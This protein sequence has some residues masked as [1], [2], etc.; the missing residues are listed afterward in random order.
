M[1]HHTHWT[2]LPNCHRKRT[3]AHSSN[4]RAQMAACILFSIEVEKKTACTNFPQE[5]EVVLF[6]GS[7]SSTV[8]WKV[9]AKTQLGAF[10]EPTI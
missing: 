10:C 7:L 2:D 6:L 9:E 5:D 8:L 4:D 1:M 3:V